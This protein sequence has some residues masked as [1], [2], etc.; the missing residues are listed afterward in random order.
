MRSEYTAS[1]FCHRKIIPSPSQYTIMYVYV[2]YV[3][4]SSKCHGLH[5]AWPFSTLTCMHAS[6]LCNITSNFMINITVCLMMVCL[7]KGAH[8]VAQCTCLLTTWEVK[9]LPPTG[10]AHTLTPLCTRHGFSAPFHPF[11]KPEMASFS[12]PTGPVAKRQT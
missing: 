7:S 2:S 4:T 8:C 3:Y 6:N 10:K 9:V 1:Y 11:N 12:P 5:G